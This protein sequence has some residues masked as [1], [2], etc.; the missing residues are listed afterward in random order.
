MKCALLMVLGLSLM[1]PAC[2][3]ELSHFAPEAVDDILLNPRMGMYMSSPPLEPQEDEWYLDVC[4]IAYYRQHWADLNPE[5][6]VYTFD[7]YFDPI[8]AV[9]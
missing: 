3:L 5:E 1:L 9:K 6:G 8:S 7:E 2:A 4:D